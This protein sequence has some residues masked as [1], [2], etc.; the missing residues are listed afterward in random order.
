MREEERQAREIFEH[1]TQVVKDEGL[2]RGVYIG[3]PI[4][5]VT[6][7]VQP[8]RTGRK[9]SF[10]SSFAR[11]RLIKRFLLWMS[12]LCIVGLNLL[13]HDRTLTFGPLV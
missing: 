11:T 10:V 8:N 2:A 5:D 12:K 6:L 9:R 4:C 7:F 13:L 3:V 1:S